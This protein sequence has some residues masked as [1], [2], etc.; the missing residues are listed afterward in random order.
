MALTASQMI[1]PGS[2][3]LA[4]HP[5]HAWVPGVVENFDGKLG[6][7]NISYP[8]KETISKLK[9]DDIFI[10]DEK[11]MEEDVPRSTQPL[12]LA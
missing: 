8:K 3:C 10:C 1:I 9:E 12:R 6:V 7:V 4:F 11:A 5:Q 2:T